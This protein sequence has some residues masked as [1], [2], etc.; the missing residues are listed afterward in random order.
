MFNVPETF[1]AKEQYIGVIFEERPSPSAKHLTQTWYKHPSLNQGKWFTDILFG[2]KWEDDE[3]YFEKAD[4]VASS[5][6][7]T[8]D[9]N[10]LDVEAIYLINDWGG[11]AE[12]LG[13]RSES[14]EMALDAI[15]DNRSLSIED[16]CIQINDYLMTHIHLFDSYLTEKS[17]TPR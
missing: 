4:A 17:E 3:Y 15:Q 13:K 11:F 7:P 10:K 1:L 9:N 16:E 8:Y 14:H 12:W 6:S 2:E 5:N